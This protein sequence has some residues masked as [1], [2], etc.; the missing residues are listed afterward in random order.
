ML[1]SGTKPTYYWLIRNV[2]PN[3]SLS[4]LGNVEIGSINPQNIGTGGAQ[5]FVQGTDNSSATYPVLIKNLAGTSIFY[6]ANNGATTADTLNV[7]GGY[8][9]N[10]IC[11]VTCAGAP[12]SSFASVNG[13]VTHC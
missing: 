5:F 4:T 10:G 11:G 13:I 2:E 8:S 7:T 3:A 6:V 1:G 12:T 9:A